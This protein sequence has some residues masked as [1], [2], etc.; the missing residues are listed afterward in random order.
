M[1]QVLEAIVRDGVLW[2]LEPIRLPPGTR[3][4]AVVRRGP[5]TALGEEVLAE[6]LRLLAQLAALAGWDPSSEGSHPPTLE[7]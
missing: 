4:E 7:W 5:A 3:V 2:P 1:T 6:R